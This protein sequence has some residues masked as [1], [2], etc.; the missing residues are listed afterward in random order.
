[1]KWQ[2]GLLALGCGSTGV[3]R[4]MYETV[5]LFDCSVYET[6]I[7]GGYTLIPLSCH[8]NRAKITCRLVAPIV[9]LFLTQRPYHTI[10]RLPLDPLYFAYPSGP[11]TLIQCTLADINKVG[12]V[13]V[14]LDIERG[15]SLGLRHC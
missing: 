15:F 5:V 11:A 2:N 4:N 14:D 13:R 10:T 1:M 6:N 9:A 12:V 7:H 8:A 3:Q